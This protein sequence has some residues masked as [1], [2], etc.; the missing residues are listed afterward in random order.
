MTA[1]SVGTNFQ[2][3]MADLSD[4][5]PLCFPENQWRSMTRS[6]STTDRLVGTII[7]Y[8]LAANGDHWVSEIRLDWHM[9]KQASRQGADVPSVSRLV[10]LW[11]VKDVVDTLWT[12]TPSVPDFNGALDTNN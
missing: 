8:H 7:K 6:A 12:C 5:I 4:A 11:L 1:I 10:E 2:P 3:T 9:D